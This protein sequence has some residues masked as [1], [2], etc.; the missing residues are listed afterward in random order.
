[1][2]ILY[3]H[4][5]SRGEFLNGGPANIGFD[6]EFDAA[7]VGVQ[8]GEQDRFLLAVFVAVKRRHCP[9]GVTVAGP[10]HLYDFGAEYGE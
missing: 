2:K 8:V 9:Q 10:L 1:M 7:L 4:V 3:Q 5:G 6:I